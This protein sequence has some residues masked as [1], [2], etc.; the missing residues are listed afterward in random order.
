LVIVSTIGS[1]H[2]NYS[3][4]KPLISFIG[5]TAEGTYMDGTELYAE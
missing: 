4:F 3:F 1:Y 5:E 2:I